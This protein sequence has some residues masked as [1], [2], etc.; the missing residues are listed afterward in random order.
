MV[1]PE[2]VRKVFGSVRVA[3]KEEKTLFS[4]LPMVVG[5]VRSRKRKG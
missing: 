2:W 5:V 3:I 4:S 1:L